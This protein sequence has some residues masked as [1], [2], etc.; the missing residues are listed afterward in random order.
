[1]AYMLNFN[2]FHVEGRYDA[3]K[4]DLSDCMNVP[5]RA[6][7]LFMFEGDSLLLMEEPLHVIIP[8]MLSLPQIRD[9]T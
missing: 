6:E 4:Y 5:R 7:R 1:M 8:K 3:C 2:L 9:L